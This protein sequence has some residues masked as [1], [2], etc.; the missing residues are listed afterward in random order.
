MSATKRDSEERPDLVA[1]L[2]KLGRQMGETLDAAWN[3]AEKRH[4]EEELRAGARAF[5]EEFERAMGKAR[6]ARPAGMA[7]KARR[8]A[9]DGLRWMSAELENLAGR[10]TPVEEEGPGEPAANEG[11]RQP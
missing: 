5:A 1:E 8:S 6:T 2:R 11:D 4:L 7:S 10:F 9:F 3:S